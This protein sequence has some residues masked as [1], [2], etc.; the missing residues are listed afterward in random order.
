MLDMGFEPQIRKIIEQIRPDRQVLMWSATWPKEVR[1]LAEEFL[2]NYLQI[3]IGSLQLAAN[4]NIHQIVE[5]CDDVE[6]PDM[7][8]KLLGDISHEPDNKAIIF[9]ETKRGVDEITR[10]VQ[11]NGF[12]AMAIHGDK[13]QQDRDYV[14]ADFRSGRTNILVA[15][16]VA[17]RGLDVDDVKFVINYDYPQSSEDYVHR[18]GRT[19]RSS[20]T[21]TSYTFFTPSNAKQ[22]SDL[23]SVLQEAGQEVSARLYQLAEMARS[24][25]F[26]KG[27]R[28]RFRMDRNYD[29]GRRDRGGYGRGSRG[30][31]RGGRDGGRF[32]GG[33]GG[34]FG[35]NERS[36]N[37]YETRSRFSG[38]KGNDEG[39]RFGAGK[40]D[41]EGNGVSSGRGDDNN[42]FGGGRGSDGGRFGGRGGDRGRF[43]DGGRGGG[44]NSNE[45]NASY[46]GGGRGGA[47]N[48]ERGRGRGMGD[49]GRGGGRPKRESR[50]GE[51]TDEQKATRSRR[52]ADNRGPDADDGGARPAPLMGNFNAPPP[53]YNQQGMAMNFG[54]QFQPPS[55][56]GGFGFQNQIGMSRN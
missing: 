1:N 20:K 33:G 46:M 8:L 34:R 7:L 48:N 49:R 21:G 29:G 43:G 36:G 12:N 25:A 31:P 32:S 27:G 28:S 5:V 38:S 42:R 35:G 15:T 18:I 37:E 23:I 56:N 3:N 54:Q 52:N 10:A 51:E 55:M 41:N 22:A 9:V 39:N 13:S 53:G 26:G 4:H 2:N 47:F 24:G 11:R 19:G 44:R 14:L 40:G 16:D 17:A 50:W 6:K 30:G 45:D